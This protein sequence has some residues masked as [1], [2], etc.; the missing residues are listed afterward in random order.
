MNTLRMLR[1]VGSA[2]AEA[3]VENPHT[4]FS[5]VV[6]EM[7]PINNHRRKWAMSNLEIFYNNRKEEME[8]FNRD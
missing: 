6:E 4:F 1:I 2:Q 3:R 5:K 8:I 7:Y